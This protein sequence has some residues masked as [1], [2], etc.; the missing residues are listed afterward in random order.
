SAT[1]TQTV[2]P[3][4]TSQTGPP[5]RISPST[6][7]TTSSLVLRCVATGCPKTERKITAPLGCTP[8]GQETHLRFRGRR[9]HCSWC[10]LDCGEAQLHELERTGAVYDAEAFVGGCLCPLSLLIGP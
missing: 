4:S 7:R 6:A 9:M 8:Y 2:S 10:V 1:S 5:P 3:G